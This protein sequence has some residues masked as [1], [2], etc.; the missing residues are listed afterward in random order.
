MDK[1]IACHM[2]SVVVGGSPKAGC[3][4]S[5]DPKTPEH[6]MVPHSL[7]VLITFGTMKTTLG[8]DGCMEDR[9]V[10]V[11]LLF[12]STCETDDAIFQNI[13]TAVPQTLLVSHKFTVHPH[14]SRVPFMIPFRSCHSSVVR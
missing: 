5:P 8:L 4:Q 3:L 9:R 12:A 1:V 13:L 7:V 6:S 11:K 10:L 2:A 14:A